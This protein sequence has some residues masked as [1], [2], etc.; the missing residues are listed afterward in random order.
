LSLRKKDDGSMEL[1][2]TMAMTEASATV[3]LKKV[4]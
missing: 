3:V 4:K 2:G 1:R